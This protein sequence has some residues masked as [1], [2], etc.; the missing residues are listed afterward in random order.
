MKVINNLYSKADSN[1]FPF[2]AT[3]W[4]QTQLKPQHKHNLIVQD[5]LYIPYNKIID[6]VLAT[7]SSIYCVLAQAVKS[8]DKLIISFTYN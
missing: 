5:Y 7:L 8:F 6:A 2:L 4:Q 1:S 3:W